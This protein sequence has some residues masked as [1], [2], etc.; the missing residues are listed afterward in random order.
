MIKPSGP[1]KT[2]MLWRHCCCRYGLY[3]LLL[4]PII[5]LGFLLTCYSSVGCKFVEIDIGFEPTNEGWNA[6]APY[7]FGL[8]YY[9]NST[10]EHEN[11]NQN[12]FH[13]GCTKF[14]D[15]FYDKFIE[16]DRTFKM[17]RIMTMISCA[18]SGLAMVRRL[19]Q[20]EPLLQRLAYMN[21]EYFAYLS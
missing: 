9:H 18:S 11:P 8:F 15:T 1:T 20:S 16:S 17:T 10:I 13:S 12:F 4:V 14:P 21:V 3:P 2:W 7:H 5:T 6:T 19:Q